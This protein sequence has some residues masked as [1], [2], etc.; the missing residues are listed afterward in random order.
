MNARPTFSPS[1]SGLEAATELARDIARLT[2]A[3]FSVAAVEDGYLVRPVH[4]SDAET[5]RRAVQY[6]GWAV[7]HRGDAFIAMPCGVTK[8]DPAMARVAGSSG[9]A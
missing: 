9:W 8:F 4:G 2:A 6:L 3:P 1:L 5:L 7:S